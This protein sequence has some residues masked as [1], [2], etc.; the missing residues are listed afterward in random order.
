MIYVQPRS[1]SDLRLTARFLPFS[2]EASLLLASSEPPSFAFAA[3]R[4]GFSSLSL[5]AL[6]GMRVLRLAYPAAALPKYSRSPA[7]LRFCRL[8]SGKNHQKSPRSLKVRQTPRLK[9]FI[10][11]MVSLLSTLFAQNYSSSTDTNVYLQSNLKDIKFLL[12]KETSF[13]I[14]R[15]STPSKDN[16]G[17]MKSPVKI[18]TDSGKIGWLDACNINSNIVPEQL[19]YLNSIL[20]P[21]YYRDSL[22][23]RSID[24]IIE[25][26]YFDPEWNV[27]RKQM[28]SFMKTQFSPWIIRISEPCISFVG[29]ESGFVLAIDSFEDLE[30]KKIFYLSNPKI[31]GLKIIISIEHN[32]SIL[33]FTLLDSSIPTEDLYFRVDLLDRDYLYGTIKDIKKIRS[34]V[35]N[36]E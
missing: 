33:D 35:I 3:I 2:S 7:T 30:D 16:D 21:T 19:D 27:T 10:F 17:I 28:I 13:K 26:D 25:N 15:Y 14:D 29:P 5:S 18:I 9:C 11:V 8:A 22:N 12:K 23:R 36:F 6:F 1:L 31:E 24:S 20:L 32:D 4:G 34:F